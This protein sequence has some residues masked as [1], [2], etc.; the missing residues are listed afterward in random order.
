MTGQKKHYKIR[1]NTLKYSLDSQR[2]LLPPYTNTFNND[3]TCGCHRRPSFSIPFQR[4]FGDPKPLPRRPDSPSPLWF[5]RYKSGSGTRRKEP[6]CSGIVFVRRIYRT[7][8]YI[9]ST[10]GNIRIYYHD[11][12]RD[13]HQT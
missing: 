8:L 12:D 10:K 2:V 1:S 13:T 3:S 6:V 7:L 5:P 9:S 4:F 11:N